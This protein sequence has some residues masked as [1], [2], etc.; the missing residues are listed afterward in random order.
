[1]VINN[2]KKNES[3]YPCKPSQMHW[4]ALVRSNLKLSTE[5]KR[6]SVWASENKLEW[7]SVTTLLRDPPNQGECGAT[8]L[9]KQLGRLGLE[10]FVCECALRSKGEDWG[11]VGTKERQAVGG[12]WKALFRLAVADVGSVWEPQLAVVV[13]EVEV[14]TETL[15]TESSDVPVRNSS[16]ETLELIGLEL[17]LGSKKTYSRGAGSQWTLI[18]GRKDKDFGGR[19][20]PSSSS[21]TMVSGM[22]LG[23]EFRDSLGVVLAARE[24]KRDVV[25]EGGTGVD[26]RVYGLKRKEAEAGC[27][28]FGPF[29]LKKEK[30]N[31]TQN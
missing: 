16:S 23:E 12:K 6:N 17:G 7:W 21:K 27:R 22:C 30:E 24:T 15:P 20:S 3:S 28:I 14:P 10:A 5:W 1:M 2:K 11:E 26:L 29:R 9:L 18:V 31:W 19:L 13:L 4:P 25:D 8:R